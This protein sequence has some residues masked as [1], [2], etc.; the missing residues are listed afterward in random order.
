MQLTR[1][2]DYAVR[3][4]VHLGLNGHRRCTVPEI[5]SAYGISESHLTKVV[6]QLGRNGFVATARGRNGGLQL[7]LPPDEIDLGTVFRATEPDFHLAECFAGAGSNSC[8]I[9]GTCVL[10]GV[11][12]AALEAFL[13]VLDRHTLADLLTPADALRSRLAA[14]ERAR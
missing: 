5:A 13:G 7:A 12:E 1:H 11:L 10:T 2:S 14:I 9:S 4:L 3:V 8:A 6:H